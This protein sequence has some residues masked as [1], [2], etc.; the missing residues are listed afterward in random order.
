MWNNWFEHI[1]LSMIY[2]S[3]FSNNWFCQM[4][5]DENDVYIEYSVYICDSLF[6]VPYVTEKHVQ[7]WSNRLYL[8]QMQH[9]K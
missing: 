9:D 4:L 3:G 7:V 2:S 6:N 1:V 8:T 5:D